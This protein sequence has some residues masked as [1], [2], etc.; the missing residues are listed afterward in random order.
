MSNEQEAK[1]LRVAKKLAKDKKK[2]QKD[3]LEL[4]EKLKQQ[5]EINSML[6]AE[7]ETDKKELIDIFNV[8]MQ[9]KEFQHEE[10]LKFS[11]TQLYSENENNFLKITE[12]FKSK[13][14]KTIE[15]EEKK[16]SVRYEEIKAS[17]NHQL[18]QADSEKNELILNLENAKTNSQ[19]II[20]SLNE[21][22]S[23]NTKLAQINEEL[24]E[25]I[26]NLQISLKKATEN[27]ELKK[28]ETEDLYVLLKKNSDEINRLR[29]VDEQYLEKFSKT[30]LTYNQERKE[31]L[32]NLEDHKDKILQNQ[33]E[34]TE[35]IL[36]LE[37]E[38]SREQ[39]RVELLNSE[40][41][42][43]SSLHLE[44]SQNYTSQTDKNSLLQ[45]ENSRL[46]EEVEILKNV[47]E[48]LKELETT[49]SNIKASN[50]AYF[51][52]I[53]ELENS[54]LEFFKKNTVLSAKN[55]DL[56]Y[57][58]EMLEEYVRELRLEKD[59]LN[60]NCEIFQKL[61]LELNSKNEELSEV[62]T[63]FEKSSE[64]FKA[65][66]EDNNAL[67]QLNTKL[68]SDV[69]NLREK[70]QSAE[71][72]LLSLQDTE[73]KNKRLE[74]ALNE[75]STILDLTKDENSVLRSRNSKFIEENYDLVTSNFKKEKDIQGLKKVEEE[76]ARL[77]K[78]LYRQ[79]SE[80]DE[81]RF[82]LGEEVGKNSLAETRL[83]Q[84]EKDSENLR[85][86]MLTLQAENMALEERVNNLLEEEN[87][88]YIE[89]DKFIN[90]QQKQIEE[91]KHELEIFSL[92]NTELQQQN[93]V[94]FSNVE[95][96]AQHILRELVEEKRKKS[97]N[98]VEKSRE[99]FDKNE[100]LLKL[101]CELSENL[102]SRSKEL[103]NYKLKYDKTVGEMSDENDLVR[104]QLHQAQNNLKKLQDSMSSLTSQITA[105]F[106]KQKVS[107]ENELETKS[108]KA[109]EMERTVHEL[110]ER[111][112]H[113][114]DK[115]RLALSHATSQYQTELEDNK[116]QVANL[117]KELIDMAKKL[118]SL[119]LKNDEQLNIITR[120]QKDMLD[121]K[122]EK[123][124]LQEGYVQEQNKLFSKHAQNIADLLLEIEKQKSEIHRL[125]NANAKELDLLARQSYLLNLNKIT[126]EKLSLMRDI[127]E[128]E[129]NNSR[130]QDEFRKLQNENSELKI[131]I[132]H[133][134]NFVE[135]GYD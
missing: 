72:L 45:E 77:H 111:L 105:S 81:I 54:N 129:M 117:K 14:K 3:V 71:I 60:S 84:E 30:E 115:N 11:K 65:C 40:N 41:S 110:L 120:A 96:D 32:K 94:I 19:N 47:K 126:E 92:H 53:G 133:V 25:R 132:G 73:N 78:E 116:N 82:L 22:K 39:G 76:N 8:E 99:L 90:E 52:K 103:L 83:K 68:S 87:S 57:E 86:N 10:N 66:S 79:K 70:L 35:T 101:N 56:S 59:A 108:H 2:L 128:S 135:Q 118:S 28:K 24:Q 44:L 75:T 46:N 33:K 134:E 31:F 13:I 51:E 9:K 37:K 48:S 64:E 23:F 4:N 16:A 21:E 113:N 104:Q 131:R 127:D 109:A 18:Q 91:L 100:A 119:S 50:H 107:L 123:N 122:S 20:D 27:V 114:E 34:N 1:Y 42:R 124:F 58:Y 85:V 125:E 61:N 112:K 121:L 5:E 106:N 36:K 43:L 29:T 95:K 89:H 49:F 38:L 26:N 15:E 12:E 67:K 55:A 130:L 63:D 17:F 69:E 7:K 62:L 80:L 74:K 88:V 93:E 102:E 6:K 98:D 97:F